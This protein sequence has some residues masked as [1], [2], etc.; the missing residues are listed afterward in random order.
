MILNRRDTMRRLILSLAIAIV[1]GFC[2]VPCQAQTIPPV[3]TKALDDSEVVLPKPGGRQLLILV[4]G[5]SHKSG[6]NCT[7]WDQRLAADYLSDPHVTYY[8]LP[9]LADAPS[10][11][12]PMILHGMH[13]NVPAVQHS[14]FVPIYDH[15][16]DW[17]KLVNFSAPDDPYILVA[18]PDG[19]VLWQ[20]HGLATDSAYSELK[21]AVAQF[22]AKSQP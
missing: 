12:R 8:Q 20:S 4:L 16:T 5:F 10:F 22:S 13:K 2:A 19:H 7:P 11:V 21:S 18:A 6:Q 17:K 15:E 9:V 3:K 14:H 1:L